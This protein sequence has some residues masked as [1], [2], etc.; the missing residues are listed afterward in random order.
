MLSSDQM[1]TDV[2]Q[3]VDCGMD[4]QKSLCLSW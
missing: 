4:T 3:V 2:E 1:S